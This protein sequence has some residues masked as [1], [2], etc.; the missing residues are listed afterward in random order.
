MIIEQ[1]ILFNIHLIL[2]IFT[3]KGKNHAKAEQNLNKAVNKSLR[4]I[5]L[6][7]AERSKISIL[8]CLIPSSKI[9]PHLNEDSF[10]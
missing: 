5:K 3:L 1:K 2:S 10:L 8:P 6:N 9:V 4:S 7:A